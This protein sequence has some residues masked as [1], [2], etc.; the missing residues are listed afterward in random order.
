MQP[1]DVLRTRLAGQGEPKVCARER[2]GG[3]R[4]RERE[5]L[6]QVWGLT[7]CIHVIYAHAQS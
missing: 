3:G 6:H 7:V 2:E 4:E 1:L 5:N